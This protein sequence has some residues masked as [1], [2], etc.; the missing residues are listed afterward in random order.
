MQAL[1]QGASSQ[2]R[3]KIGIFTLSAVSTNTL[4]IGAGLSN[5]AENNVLPSECWTAQPISQL[6]HPMHLSG[7]TYMASIFALPLY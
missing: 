2:W 5:S 7:L 3:H 1:R 6:L 4:F